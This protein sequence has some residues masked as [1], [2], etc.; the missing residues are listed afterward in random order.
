MQ[1]ELQVRLWLPQFPQLWLSV[2]PGEQDPW[3]WQ[4]PQDPQLQLEL[5]V[6]VCVPQ[7]PQAWVWLCPG[8]QVPCPEHALHPPQ[9]HE[10]VQTRVW[11]PQF[12]Q[13]WLWVSPGEQEKVSSIPPSQSSSW[14]LHSSSGA[15]GHWTTHICSWRQVA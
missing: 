14:P 8:E 7:R 3:P 6:M 11:F 4:E 13:D 12:P 15:A 5:Q 10:L 1:F 9:V 2:C